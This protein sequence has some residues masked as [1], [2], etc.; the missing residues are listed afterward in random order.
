[1]SLPAT[2]LRVLVVEDEELLAEHLHVTLEALGYTVLGPA[3]DADTALALCQETWPDVAVLDI[4]LAGSRSGIDLARELQARRPLPLVFLTALSGAEAF[5]LAR[6]VGPAAY[7]V[8]PAPADALQRALEL[9]VANSSTGHAEPDE[10]HS[11]FNAASAILLPDA[12]FVKEDGLLVKVRLADICSIEAA[13]KQC[14]LNLTGRVLSVRQP[15]RELT[16]RLPGSDFV[17]IHRRYV[18][19]AAC[20]ERLDTVRNLV[21][22]GEQVLPLGQTY[23]EHL[24]Q[25]LQQ[26]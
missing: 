4:T 23:R 2:P 19:N 11:V 26:V 8:K 3:P 17:Q 20:I 12:L 22:V 16:S 10:E 18:V 9:A 6:A 15:L 14:L 7:L 25:R 5:S 24:L 21:Q 13:D 1:M